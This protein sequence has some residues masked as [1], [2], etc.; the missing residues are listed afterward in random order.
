MEPGHILEIYALRWGIEVSFKESKCH[1]GLLKEQTNSFA[2]HIAS[3]H[4][5]AIRFCMLIYAKQEG[6]WFNGKRSKKSGRK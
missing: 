3:T 6:G 1:L 4:L 5:A 2:S